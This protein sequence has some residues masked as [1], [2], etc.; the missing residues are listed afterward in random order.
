M[1][2]GGAPMA[3]AKTGGGQAYAS[4][5]ASHFRFTPEEVVKYIV[6]LGVD[7]PLKDW[8]DHVLYDPIVQE[9]LDDGILSSIDT[10]GVLDPIEVTPMEIDGERRPV[11]V[12]GRGRV[13]HLRRVNELR[14]QRGDAPYSLDATNSTLNE[15]EMW[16]HKITRNSARRERSL[17]TKISEAAHVIKGGKSKDDAAIAFAVSVSTIE[18]WLALAK[19][20]KKIRDAV[21]KG[22]IPPTAGYRL[23]KL[24]PDEQED[25]L[26][27]L[28]TQTGGKRGTARAAQGVKSR[29]KGNGGA[30]AAGSSP[31]TRPRPATIKKLIVA[32]DKDDG[33]RAIVDGAG[34]DL[35]RWIT[36][37][38]TDRVLPKALRDAMKGDDS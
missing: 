28:L 25:A 26:E 14:I 4:A 8:E 34:Y 21:S 31:H 2:T 20:K 22:V 35:C 30:A 27:E 10:V 12:D 17:M 1:P 32:A 16:L 5:R 23:A 36:G 33:V 29:R 19:A 18:N 13:M 3:A 9:P 38:V 6:V 37:E 7:T 15:D 11:V 24:P